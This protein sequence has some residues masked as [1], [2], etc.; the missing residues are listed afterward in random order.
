DLLIT[1]ELLYQLSYT[2]SVERFQIMTAE[3]RPG[4]DRPDVA[5]SGLVRILNG[6]L[7]EINLNFPGPSTGSARAASTVVHR[8]DRVGE[9]RIR[10]I[11]ATAVKIVHLAD[12]A[13]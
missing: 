10:G 3:Y 9:E 11:G 8:A 6:R 5:R 7:R 13:E 4:C 2:S 1:S 12:A